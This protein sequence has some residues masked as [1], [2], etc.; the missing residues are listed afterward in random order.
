MD[1]ERMKGCKDII[2]CV[3]VCACVCARA[4][5]LGRGGIGRQR[6]GWEIRN[7]FWQHFHKTRNPQSS[8]L[9]K[10]ESHLVNFN[11]DLESL[12]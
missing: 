6:G 4:C 10:S 7:I 9:I 3:C 2:L 1:S 12:A 11:I 5:V 8:Y